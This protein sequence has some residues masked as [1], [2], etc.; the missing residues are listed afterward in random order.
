MG[1]GPLPAGLM[2]GSGAKHDSRA[3]EDLLTDMKLTAEVRRGLGMDRRELANIESLIG[4]REQPL[5]H[6]RS[7]SGP[8]QLFEHVIP[9]ECSI[10]R[11]Q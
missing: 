11:L 6:A 5:D 3:T 4:M 9:L 7:Q 8:K 1:A 2:C 10:L